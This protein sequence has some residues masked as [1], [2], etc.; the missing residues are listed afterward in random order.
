MNKKGQIGQLISIVPI[1]FLI[2]IIMAIFVLIASAGSINHAENSFVTGAVSQGN[3][4][5]RNIVV[6]GKTTTIRGA[7]LDVADNYVFDEKDLDNNRKWYTPLSSGLGVFLDRESQVAG[8][9]SCLVIFARVDRVVDSSYL[10]GLLDLMRTHGGYKP[11]ADDYGD[12]SFSFYFKKSGGILYESHSSVLGN[13]KK[14]YLETNS[15]VYF[16]FLSEKNKVLNG[17]YYYGECLE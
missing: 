16:S 11:V 4:M 7:L 5:E 2:F 8:R 17:A 12:G 14:H 15:L 1:M 13:L 9:D 3:L 10:S 6:S